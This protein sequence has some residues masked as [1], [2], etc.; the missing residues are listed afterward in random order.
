MDTHT[1]AIDDSLPLRSA[2]KALASL[3]QREYRQGKVFPLDGFAAF[4]PPP[5]QGLSRRD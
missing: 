5:D 3:K 4:E 1:L 2:E